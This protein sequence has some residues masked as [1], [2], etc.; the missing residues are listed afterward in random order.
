MLTRMTDNYYAAFVH[1]SN[2]IT[3]H[4]DQMNMVRIWKLI[5]GKKWKS[6]KMSLIRT[7]EQFKQFKS[8]TSI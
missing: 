3:L 6:K 4:S 1:A 7:D 8:Q 5:N 2:C